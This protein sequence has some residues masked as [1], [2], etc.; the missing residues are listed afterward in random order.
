MNVQA[1]N[2]NFGPLRA[3]HASCLT[4][5][6]A[7]VLEAC[8]A[9]NAATTVLDDAGRT[10][11]LPHPARRI[12]SLAPSST[13]LLFA[14]GAGDRVIATVEFSD[15]PPAARR[16]PRIGDSNAVDFEQLIVLH[17]DVVVLWSGGNPSQA[18]R[19]ASLHIP[20]Y[21]EQ[22]SALA[23]LPASV[24]RLGELTGTQDRAASSA[25]AL[26]AE[27][28]ALRAR[29]SNRAPLSVLLQVWSH[30]IYT[31]GGTQLMSDSL[32]VCG[33][34]NIFE[35]LTA[36]G[37]A[38]TVEAVLARDPDVIVAAAPQS[39]AAEW[40]AEWR[41]FPHLKAVRADNLILFEDPRF[42]RLGPSVLPATAALCT[43]LD[44]ARARRGA[45]AAR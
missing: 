23:D 11:S 30:P 10:V 28:G 44:A 7:A 5:I 36:L 24:R 14:A 32:R 6:A 21:R 16:V 40:L 15:E 17:P 8:A 33:A 29:Y 43:A 20:L 26:A 42:V 2:E 37:P 35:D 25:A 45:A 34:R 3:A 38:V 27:L 4:L 39:S 31:V 1:M 22:V 19:V 18:A 13:E 12:V 41:K 9:A